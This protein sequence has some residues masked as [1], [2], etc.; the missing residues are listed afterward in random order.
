MGSTIAQP[1]GADPN[2]AAV[3]PFPLH[4]ARPPAPETRLARALDSLRAA[5][6][7]QREAASALQAASRQLKA[8]LA[9]LLLR[10]ETHQDRLGRLG[11]N[12]ARVNAE[13][14]R[15]EQWADGVLATVSS[16]PG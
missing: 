2:E 14:R 7:E 1:P 4:R 8:T 15:L 16:R 11:T 9:E 10:L 13:A 12:V 3:L 6:D 5:L